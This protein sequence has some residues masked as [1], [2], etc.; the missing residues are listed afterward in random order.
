MA[1]VR[2]RVASTLAAR[3]VFTA[4]L[5]NTDTVTTTAD[6]GPGSLRQKTL[7]LP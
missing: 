5:A 6:S 1:T 3:F 2:V 7:N 4:A